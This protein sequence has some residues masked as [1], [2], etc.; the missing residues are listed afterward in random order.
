MLYNK[1]KD[2]KGE[3]R[4]YSFYTMK[5]KG[6]VRLL[7]IS[8]LLLSLVGCSAKK[9]EKDT[10]EQTEETTKTYEIKED[11][12]VEKAKEFGSAVINKDYKTVLT[13]AGVED[14]TFFTGDNVE[15]YIK[16]TDYLSALLS[17]TSIEEFEKD[18]E[19]NRYY[20]RDYS[21]MN[22]DGAII[23]TNKNIFIYGQQID[24]KTCQINLSDFICNDWFFE[25]PRGAK[26]FLDDVD[27]SPFLAKEEYQREDKDVYTIPTI[28]MGI[29]KHV[30]LELNGE[31][32]EVDINTRNFVDGTILYINENAEI[33][34]DTGTEIKTAEEVNQ[35][36][37]LQE[38]RE[39]YDI[40]VDAIT[41]MDE[42]G[43]LVVT[44]SDGTQIILDENGKVVSKIEASQ[45]NE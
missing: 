25:V 18:F 8:L 20:T 11:E 43:N 36:I 44:E 12:L 37:K 22:N 30:K 5:N 10:T 34:F 17:Y 4:G 35:L 1:K 33:M 40:P 42:N 14:S 31:T 29:T 28:G 32:K 45:A 27:C 39:S 26:V 6:I 9:E 41:S 2:K 7:I 16:N 24:K 19:E 38:A 13:L 15:E 21:E 3:K 23:I